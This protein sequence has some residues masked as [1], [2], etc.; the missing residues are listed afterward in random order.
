MENSVT[1]NQKDDECVQNDKAS[2]HKLVA[3]M[4]TAYLSKPNL[5]LYVTLGTEYSEGIGFTQ[6]ANLFDSIEAACNR[7]LIH[8][9][10]YE[11]LTEFLFDKQIVGIFTSDGNKP[12]FVKRSTKSR[13]LFENEFSASLQFTLVET[14]V[15]EPLENGDPLQV[16]IYEKWTFTHKNKVRYELIK[17]TQGKSK[18]D[19]CNQEP[20]FLVRMY[21]LNDTYSSTSYTSVLIKKSFDVFGYGPNPKLTHIPL[22]H[23]GKRKE[24]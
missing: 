2:L 5:I 10:K 4:C 20:K 13:L 1:E 22:R 18:V 14:N 21:L 8:F 11:L 9:T 24:V 17:T 6:F 15:V 12:T 19:A 16:Q 7:S 23:K 3:N